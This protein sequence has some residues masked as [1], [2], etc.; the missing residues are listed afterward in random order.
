MKRSEA[1]RYARWSAALALLL[2]AIT[3]GVY[4]RHGVVARIQK[5]K[6]P[7]APANNVER[8]SNGLTFSKVEG[9]RKVFTVEASKSTEYR[10]QD[11]SLLEEVKITIFGPHSERHDTIRTRSCQYAKRNGSIVCSGSVQIDLQS[12]A[13]AELAAHNSGNKTVQPAAHVETRNVKFEQA[14][15]VARTEERVTFTFPE[16]TGEAAGVEYNSQLGTLQLLHEVKMSLRQTGGP[17]GAAGQEVHVS[18]SSLDFNRDTRLLRLFGPAH[19]ESLTAKLEAGEISMNLDEDYRAQKVLATA[20][21]I[22]KKPHAASS[23]ATGAMTLNANVITAWFDA[24]GWLKKLDATGDVDG[25]R[26]SSVEDDEFT[27]ANTS[28]ELWPE[29]TEPK[30]MNMRGNVAIKTSAKNGQ[31]RLLETDKLRMDFTE[32]RDEKPSRP[33]RAETLAAGTIQWMDS[34]G[35]GNRGGKV[36]DSRTRLQADKFV[37]DFAAGA[38][39]QLSATGNVQAERTVPGGASQVSTARRGSV[40]LAAG[41]GWTQIDL[42][43]D[44]RLKDG[45]RS[46][47]GDHATAVRAAESMTLTGHAVVRDAATETRAA[48]I[49]FQQATGDISADGGVRSSTIPGKNAAPQFSG[50]PATIAADAMQG[51]AKTGRALYS[52]HARLR[53]GDSILEAEAI[54]LL[55]KTRQLNARGNVRAVFPQAAQREAATVAVSAKPSRKSNLWHLAA[56]SLT[57]EDLGDHA[58]VE[59]NVLVQSEGQRIRCGL[60]DLYFSRAK[61]AGAVEQGGAPSGSAG[62]AQQISR[63]V[64]TGGVIV[65][66]QSRKATAERAE[67][68]AADGKF[69][70]SGG[71]PTLFDGTQGTT[72]GRQLTFFLAD[73]TIIVDSENGSRTLTKHRVEK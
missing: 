11:A 1:A 46:G 28:M 6:A 47:Q 50:A 56:K 2:A 34:P 52:G 35:D 36:G 13:A 55:Q 57:Y 60:L 14:T 61:T 25:S 42:D 7:P 16:G 23:A 18:G 37:L 3:V 26:K 4:L 67:Y 5:R 17:R 32:G 24:A 22:G 31:A 49:S 12:A 51:N 19:A 70:M 68:T 62:G 73:D 20:G 72:V 33:K 38:A 45:D 59:G 54:E 30:Q 69:V 27:A 64:G 40:Q 10:D 63:A 58:R 65:E 71:N 39:S 43:G 53:Q 8:Q 9:D 29:I 48:K 15:G 44:V 21:A 41:A 66:E